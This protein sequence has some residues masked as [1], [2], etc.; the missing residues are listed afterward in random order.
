MLLM[1]PAIFSLNCLHNVCGCS[2]GYCW[3]KGVSRSWEMISS[4]QQDSDCIIGCSQNYTC[5]V[6][7]DGWP[8]TTST[9]ITCHTSNDC[10]GNTT[11][12]LN[13]KK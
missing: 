8:S 12:F 4:C 11:Q 1:I 7:S 13:E 5:Q 3:K 9:N 10:K 2:D 6:A